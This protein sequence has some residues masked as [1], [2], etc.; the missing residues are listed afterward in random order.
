MEQAGS[1]SAG[2]TVSI[3]GAAMNRSEPHTVSDVGLPAG[4]GYRAYQLATI[5]SQK[6][7]MACVALRKDYYPHAPIAGGLEC[8]SFPYPNHKGGISVMVRVKDQ[9]C[10]M[11]AVPVVDSDWRH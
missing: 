10:N 3:L 4:I 2:T 5:E 8:I 9:P 11:F 7:C 1:K 6:R